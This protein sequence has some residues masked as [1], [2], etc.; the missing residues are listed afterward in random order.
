MRPKAY[1]LRG[2]EVG[3]YPPFHS[4][5]PLVVGTDIK[6]AGADKLYRYLPS[7]KKRA[8]HYEADTVMS[9]RGGEC[10]L[11]PVDR[12]S[13]FTPAVKLPKGTAEAAR[14][15]MTALLAVCPRTR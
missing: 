2:G 15:A 9:K 11:S 8:E 3:I 6:P 7:H 1:P 13:R 10:L 14:D 5:G 12:K 4:R